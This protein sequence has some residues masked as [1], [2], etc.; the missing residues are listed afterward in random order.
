MSISHA[1]RKLKTYYLHEGKTK[2]GKLRY[3]FSP[4]AEGN[5]VEAVPDGYEIYENPN[6]Q[7]FLRKIADQLITDEE[8]AIVDQGMKRF[9]QLTHYKVNVKKDVISI[10]TPDQNVP[11]ILA[12]IT[13]APS[14]ASKR[15]DEILESVEQ[16]LSYSSELRFVLVDQQRRLFQT[17]RFCYLGRIDDWIDIGPVDQLATLVNTYVKHLGQ[18]SFFELM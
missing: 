7:V 3:F 16:T 8:L 9:T 6:G 17:Q 15:E 18:E 12:L 1:N 13:A 5:L 2:T 11:F 10:F 14:A 4:K